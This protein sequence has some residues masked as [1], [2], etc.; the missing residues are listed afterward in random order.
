MRVIVADHLIA[1]KAIIVQFSMK[2]TSQHL[3]FHLRDVTVPHRK[4]K[5]AYVPLANFSRQSHGPL[6]C[7]LTI[8]HH[9]ID[10]QIASTSVASVINF[11]RTILSFI[12]WK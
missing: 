9:I 12:V 8:M 5:I 4:M 6:T 11:E 3:P 7:D 10:V 1:F 2:A